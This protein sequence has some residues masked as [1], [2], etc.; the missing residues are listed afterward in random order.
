MSLS[1]SKPMQRRGFAPL[2]PEIHHAR[3]GD[4]ES[5]RALLRTICPPDELAAIFVEPIQGE[6][7]Y[8]VPPADFLPGLRAAL[9]RARDPARAR[10]GPVGHRPDRQDVR[11]R[12]LGRRRRH[13]LP[14]QGDRQ[15]PAAGRDRRAGRGDGL[16][17]RQPRLDL[18]RQPR[19][20]R[21]GAGDAPP[22]RDALPR[23]RRAPRPRSS[24]DGLEP[25]AARHPHHPRGPRPRPDDR[26]RDPVG[27]R[28]PTPPSATGSSTWPSAAAC[29]CSPAA[30]APSGSARPSA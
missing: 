7:G 22:R 4:L 24:R 25:L 30:R 11:L 12:A 26:R 17:Q 14:G 8:I 23:Q 9:R 28:R 6:G 2:V 29:C 21:R 20:L 18:R 16:A 1:G 5:V 27:R 3:Y 10:R 13:R 19:R 15:R